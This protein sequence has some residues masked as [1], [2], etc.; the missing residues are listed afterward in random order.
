MN[1]CMNESTHTANSELAYHAVGCAKLCSI[2]ALCSTHANQSLLLLV[3][4]IAAEIA[5]VTA[6]HVL[7]P[8]YTFPFRPFC[9]SYTVTWPAVHRTNTQLPAHTTCAPLLTAC[10]ILV[11]TTL[12]RTHK[13]SMTPEADAVHLPVNY[14]MCTPDTTTGHA[15]R[16]L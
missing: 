3:C 2:N 6:V 9:C 1:D 7:L 10:S 15:A 11:D 16:G 12:S 5:Q 14:H 4:L 13:T 8:L